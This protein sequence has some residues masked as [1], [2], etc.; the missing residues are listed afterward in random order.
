MKIKKISAIC[1]VSLA[2]TTNIAFAADFTDI[3]GHWAEST[4]NALAGQGVINGVTPTTFKPEG[5]VT[6]AEFLKMA[7]EASGI[8]P[9]AM[10][11]GECLDATQKDWFSSYLQSALDKGI[12]PEQM[13]NNCTINVLNK[14][15]ENGNVT[16][17]A[18]YDGAFLGNL[19]ITREEMAALSQITYQYALNANTMKKMKD[20]V[21]LTFTDNSA[22]SEWVLPYVKLAVAQGFITGMDNG[23]FAPRLTATRAQAA[24]IIDRI[25]NQNK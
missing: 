2:L 22:I 12:V 14:T 23:S 16:S 10:R 4:I 11:A 19:P 17:A 6:R 8:K 25:L 15:D 20:P 3:R 7:M 21:E 9:I 24:V 13:I 18:L 1:A 5:T